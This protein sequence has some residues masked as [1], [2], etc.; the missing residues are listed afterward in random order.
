MDT[1]RD[2]WKTEASRDELTRRR[3]TLIELLVV[4]AI[5]AILAAMLLPVLTRARAIAQ[6]AVCMG[7][8][9]QISLAF[10]LY[11]E[12][13]GMVPPGYTSYG[14]TE[15]NGME[16]AWG[17]ITWQQFMLPYAARELF[18]CPG[19]K[20]PSGSS[21]ATYGPFWWMN[22]GLSETR[23]CGKADPAFAGWSSTRDL[24][25]PE[26]TMQAM[27]GGNY[28]LNWDEECIPL[29]GGQGM[30]YIPGTTSFSYAPGSGSE[31]PG[32]LE[33][34]TFGRHPGRNVNV[35]YFDGHVARRTGQSVV[36]TGT[37]TDVFW[38]GD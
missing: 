26:Q 5:I 27:D 4:I 2:R 16:A 29:G 20:G 14:T 18:I 15:W 24:T 38:D 7:N 32:M 9:K 10:I 17:L 8:L 31:M 13:Y 12:D 23:S 19:A 28:Q 1:D 3:F 21:A 6:E 25:Y 35:G 37:K 22:Y 36:D 30:Y 11:E 33:D 34:F